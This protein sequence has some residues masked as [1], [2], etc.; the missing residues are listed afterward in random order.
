MVLWLIVII[1]EFAALLVKGRIE[2]Y[3]SANPV[4]LVR[5]TRLSP[6]KGRLHSSLGYKPPAT[7]GVQWPTPF[8]RTCFAGRPSYCNPCH[9][10][11]GAS[12][13]D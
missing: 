3:M 4:R 12:G 11:V 8:K 7:G 10:R 1:I 9:L 5:A 2:V 6:E 13:M